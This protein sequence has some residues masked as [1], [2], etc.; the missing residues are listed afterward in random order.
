M[1]HNLQSRVSRVRT[2]RSG[3]TNDI[4]IR[5]NTPEVLNY[6]AAAK[7]LYRRAEWVFYVRAAVG[8]GMPVLVAI[9]NLVLPRLAFAA[10]LNKTSFAAWGALYGLLV[11]LLDELVLDQWEQDWKRNA[12][13]A[14]ETFDTTLFGLHWRGAKVGAP[15]EVGDVHTWA[16][17][18]QHRDRTLVKVRNWYPAIVRCVPLDFASVVCQRANVW[19][20]SRL[21]QRYATI[22]GAFAYGV[23]VLAALVAKYFGLDVDGFLIGISTVAPAF[24]WAIRERKRH[25]ASASTLVRLCDRAREL[26]D[27]I[28][29]DR[30]D[31]AEARQQCRELQDDIFDHR[32]SAPIGFTRLYKILRPDFEPAMQASAERSVRDYRERRGLPPIEDVG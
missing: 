29:D 7:L 31:V 16:K 14:Q 18:W 17:G 24:R 28:I 30:A 2:E 1:V 6:Q 12:A 25:R 4:P 32:R 22:L 5:Q 8:V 3:D 21:R 15:L 9:A 23:V 13:T 27:G 11:M 26:H 10:S 19:W 20:D